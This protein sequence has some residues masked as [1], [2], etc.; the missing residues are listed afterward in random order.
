MENKKIKKKKK[1]GEVKFFLIK[2]FFK[3]CIRFFNFNSY[4]IL[5][6][7]YYSQLSFS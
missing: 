4:V 5:L 2:D 1:K 6:F 7:Y 3:F